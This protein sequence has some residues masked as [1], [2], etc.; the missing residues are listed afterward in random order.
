MTNGITQTLDLP[1]NDR[2][3]RVVVR[4]DTEE[5]RRWY[6]DNEKTFLDFYNEGIQAKAPSHPMNIFVEPINACNMKCPFCTTILETRPR[7]VMP[8]FILEKFLDDLSDAGIFPRLT[9]TGEG[10][11][12][13][14]KNICEMIE[15]SRA[16][17]F[18]TWSINNGTM[19][20]KD[21]IERL[22]AAKLNRVQ[23]SIDSIRPE[24]YE[25]MRVAKGNHGSYFDQVMGNIL[26]FIKRNYEEGSPTF[27]TISSVQT[28]LNADEADS[29]R[30]FWYS[31]PVNH[32]FI[33]PQST[34]Q[35]SNP[36]GDAADLLYQGDQKDKPVCS[37]PFTNAKVNSDGSVNLCT[38]DYNGIYSVGN[39]ME[40]SFINI[41]NNDK[42]QVLRQALIDGEVQGFVDMGHD[43]AQ[44]NNPFIGYGMEDYKDGSEVRLER[45]H[46]ALEENC[47]VAGADVKY[48]NLIEL[49]EKFPHIDDGTP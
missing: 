19:L 45:L 44:C 29:F 28:S 4:S 18:N 10:E 12:F 2:K 17:G 42:S 5:V 3:K 27:V 35:G 37:I 26:H 7:K 30:E 15:M 32:V 6:N 40:D 25:Q 41:W 22:I 23:F 43:C 9:F 21:R 31:L 20:T 16:R 38:H 14:H 13:L 46:A 24:I 11:P 49:A 8:L 48:S 39:V 33:Q 47:E 36:G 1:N 34:V